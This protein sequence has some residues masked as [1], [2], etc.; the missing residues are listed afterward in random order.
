MVYIVSIDYL[1][2]DCLS[3]TREK[4]MH[5]THSKKMEARSSGR[6]DVF[7]SICSGVVGDDK[8]SYPVCLSTAGDFCSLRKRRCGCI[9]GRTNSEEQDNFSGDRIHWDFDIEIAV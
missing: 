6:A 4:R 1:R 9:L 3:G 8:G 2:N 7:F 5:K